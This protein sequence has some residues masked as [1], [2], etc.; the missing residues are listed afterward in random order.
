[1]DDESVYGPVAYRLSFAAA[2]KQGIICPYKI[3]ISVTT[4]AEVDAALLKHGIT[5]VKRDKIQAKWVA[6]QLALKRA[7]K[8]TKASKVI[9]FHS[10]VALAK[11]SRQTAAAGSASTSQTSKSSTSTAGSRRRIANPC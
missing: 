8:K 9:T 7:I 5:L 6:T 11:S 10:R 4:M 3:V 2:A 1:M